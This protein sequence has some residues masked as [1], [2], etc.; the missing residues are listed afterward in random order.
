MTIMPNASSGI[1]SIPNKHLANVE[2]PQLLLI[3]RPLGV[4]KKACRSLLQ[5][6]STT[7]QRHA[8]PSS[9]GEMLQCERKRKK[10]KTKET[11]QQL[12]NFCKG[13][14]NVRMPSPEAVLLILL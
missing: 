12:L 10:E 8:V 2:A 7:P 1:V 4:Q 5:E 3:A 13:L 11:S 14:L 9:L 6:P